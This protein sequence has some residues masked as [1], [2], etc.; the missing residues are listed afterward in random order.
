MY[1]V[2]TRGIK[3]KLNSVERIAEELAPQVMCVTETML[4]KDEKI[5]IPGYR[6][7]DNNN[8]TG[9]GGIIIAVKK[10]LKDI[11]IET[12]QVTEEY[13]SLWIKIDNTRNKINVGCI[14]APQ[15]NK[16]KVSTL[17]KMYAH[18]ATH[19]LKARQDNERVII[20]GDF[21]AK[22]GNAIQ[23]NKEEVSKS[24]RLLLKTALEQELSIL[25]TSQK[26]EGKWT[27]ILGKER[28]VLDY[29]MVRMD[30][31]R[32][33]SKIKID[34][35]KEH[36]P[37][38]KEGSQVT[39]SD[40]CAIIV[41]M[42]VTEANLEQH[43]I[44]TRKVITEESLNKISQ[45]T[46]AG[47]LTK[48]AKENTGLNEK[49]DKWMMELSRIIGQTAEVK[50]NKKKQT[51]KI[52]RKMNILKK[53]VRNKPNWNRRQKKNQI[54]NINSIIE[55]EIKQQR[56]RMTIRMAK[57]L[58]TENQMHSGTF[59]EFKRRMDRKAKGETPSSMMNADGKEVTTRDEIKEVFEKFYEN[60]FN[61]D[62]PSS[63][64]EKKAEVI[65]ERVFENILKEAENGEK[66][67]E[68]NK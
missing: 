32:Y 24:G 67:K 58:Q 65:T 47:I 29:I 59:Y 37:G 19:A 40:H 41:E 55:N 35:E 45:M 2:N 42:Q 34:E 15:E 62:P 28:S 20:T 13:Q 57:D 48:I 53:K 22:I 16:T 23:G 6:V 68:K 3:S 50:R 56:A 26:C 17:N 46:E 60:L 14:Y 10:E 9:K 31:E 18:I 36:T 25:N 43:D 44:N 5:E 54:Q 8:K 30:D 21:N 66:E 52:V 38:Y 51:M 11:T 4:D 27:R 12:E 61:H 33:I 7:F 49:Y 1:Y 64:I 39:Y 63:D